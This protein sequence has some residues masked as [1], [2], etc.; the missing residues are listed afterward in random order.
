MTK[1][2]YKE[3]LPFSKKLAENLDDLYDRVFKENKAALIIIDGG[4]GEGKTTL[5]THITDYFNWKHGLE[6]ADLAEKKQLAMG[7]E[8]FAKKIVICYKESLPALG[9]D[10][11]GDFNKRGALSRFNALINRTFEIY[12][13]FKVIII[14]M[15][16]SFVVLDEE[17]FL[18]NI[19]RMLIHVHNRTNKQGNGKVF[20]LY[21]MF[22]LRHR[23]KKL[24]VKSQAYSL[25]EA[26]FHIHFKDLESRRSKQ[27]DRISITGKIKELR[28]AEIKFEG[29]LNYSDVAK[30]V[31]RSELWV[32]LALK[33]NGI[34]HVRI[35]ERR[36]YFTQDV[37]DNLLNYID[38]GGTVGNYKK[39][40]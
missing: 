1:K 33:K 31:G 24:V 12:R 18:K 16:P 9:Y 40:S 17:L 39:R 29:L 15:L 30:K 4:V 11:A 7:G 19:P 27:L 25:V 28:G 23:M 32:K 36:K 14:L 13:A 37:V 8:Q 3:D 38:E 35:F 6:P 26:S 2:D 22:Y 34:K 20:S 5:G 10:E 21:R